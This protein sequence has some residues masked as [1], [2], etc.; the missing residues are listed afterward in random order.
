M[1]TYAKNWKPITFTYSN[2][3]DIPR[4]YTG[5]YVIWYRPKNVCIYVGKAQKQPL[6]KRLHAHWRES[7]NK[8]LTQWLGACPKADID[9]C[10]RSIKTEKIDRLEKRLIRL[11]KPEA[12]GTSNPN[13]GRKGVKNV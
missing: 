9:V 11:W 4:T 2:F 7:H 1:R 6:G 5:V 13:K 10:Y 12:N 8:I 3:T